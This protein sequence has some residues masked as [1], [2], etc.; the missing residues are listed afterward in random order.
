MHVCQ[1]LKAAQCLLTV[2]NISSSFVWAGSFL[3]EAL[4]GVDPLSPYFLILAAGEF[5]GF[6]PGM[7][8]RRVQILALPLTSHEAEGKL[9][10]LAE[11]QSPDL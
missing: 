4:N 9:C 2:L 7:R 3:L 1:I 11:L 5:S 6:I 8:Q 10:H